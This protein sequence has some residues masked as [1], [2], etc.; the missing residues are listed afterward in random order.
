MDGHNDDD[1]EL[2]RWNDGRHTADCGEGRPILDRLSVIEFSQSHLEVSLLDDEREGLSHHGQQGGL[3]CRTAV[4]DLEGEKDYVDSAGE[5]GAEIVLTTSVVHSDA[6]ETIER[7]AGPDVKALDGDSYFARGQHNPPGADAS[8]VHEMFESRWVSEATITSSKGHGVPRVSIITMTTHPP[9]SDDLH[10]HREAKPSIGQGSDHSPASDSLTWV[11]HDQ[12]CAL[13]D[14]RPLKEISFTMLTDASESGSIHV[15]NGHAA[16]SSAAAA[17]PLDSDAA[18]SPSVT[19]S[20]QPSGNSHGAATITSLQGNMRVRDAIFASFEAGNDAIATASARAAHLEG[21]GGDA[22][23]D[24]KSGEAYS[25]LLQW[26]DPVHDNGDNPANVDVARPVGGDDKSSDSVGDADDSTLSSSR[27]DDPS[28]GLSAYAL[29]PTDDPPPPGQL[30]PVSS[31]RRCHASAFDA[32]AVLRS[33]SFDAGLSHLAYKAMQ[34]CGEKSASGAGDI[35]TIRK[36]LSLMDALSED[37]DSDQPDGEHTDHTPTDSSSSGSGL[38]RCSL[39]RQLSIPNVD[40]S[41]KKATPPLAPRLLIREIST[42][43]EGE[44]SSVASESLTAG[45]NSHTFRSSSSGRS[46]LETIDDEGNEYSSSATSRE[47]RDGTSSSQSD[48]NDTRLKEYQS[49]TEGD[50]DEFELEM[51]QYGAL[52]PR[53]LYT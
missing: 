47:S 15:P 3:A 42:G 13:A 24:H 53:C 9:T 18:L 32:V 20:P 36:S 12:H 5:A 6:P 16:G 34:I 29:E 49:A 28:R 38:S 8:V 35:D 52:V 50:D 40:A 10:S 1:D 14:T 23:G 2:E 7:R 25:Q 21:A 33:P 41:S 48:G 44:E 17:V 22:D 26:P 4:L 43:T 19:T 30:V 31:S 39:P 45:T 37:E 46:T 11:S 27:P 51:G